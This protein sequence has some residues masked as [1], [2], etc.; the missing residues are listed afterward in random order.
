MAKEKYELIIAE[1]PRVSQKIASALSTGE[2]QQKK[3]GKVSYYIIERNGK[4]IVVAPAVGHIFTLK[5]SGTAFGYPI[6]DIKWVPTYLA[7]KNAYYTREYIENLRELS[8]NAD[9]FVSACDY[10]I[11]GELIGYNVLK[12]ICG[13]DSLK[14]ARRMKFSTLTKEELSNA[15]KN[16]LK[17][18]DFNMAYAGITRHILDWYYGINVS[19][20]LSYAYKAVSGGY[21]TLSAGRVQTPTLR[22]LDDREKEIKAFVPEPFWVITAIL[23]NDINA[24]HKKEKFFKKEDAEGV[25]AKC[26]GKPAVVSKIVKRKTK[27]NPPTPF[28]LGD[29]QSEAY[30]VFKYSPKRTQSLAQSLYEKGLISYPRTSSQKLPKRDIRE[31]LGKLLNQKGYAALVSELLEKRELKAN[32]GK[33]TDPAHPCIYPTGEVPKDLPPAELKLYD[34]IVKRFLATFGKPAIRETQTITFLIDGEEFIAKGTIT[35]EENWFVF[36]SPYVKLKEEELPPVKEKQVL[37]VKKIEKKEDKTKPPNRYSQ[38]SIIRKMEALGIGTKAT[39]A[40]ILQ[41]LY[42]R[43]Y[44]EGTQIKVTLFGSKVI[45]TLSDYVPELTSEK[46]TRKFE[47]EIEKIREGKLQKESVL[48]EAKETLIKILKKFKEH[49]GEIGKR[50]VEEHMRSVREQREIGTCPKCGG[51]LIIRV[52]KKS[53]KQFIGCSNYPKCNVSY[54]LP[55]GA[56][57]VKTDKKCEY[58]GLPIIEVRRRGRRPYRMCIDPNCPSKK[59]WKSNKK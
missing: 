14:K 31:L 45:E 23:E 49:E 15:Y 1:K 36:Y 16:I 5:E 18:I 53:G 46:L 26:K 20:A 39:R 57:I 9:S 22:I 58:D 47:E 8:K 43:G 24:I 41:T 33:K 52:S 2:I 4:K 25:Y 42:D 48:L 59:N 30:K 6:F 34:L 55:Q 13:E 54:P 17:S 3:R 44:V 56:K 38:A 12:F 11:E 10:D 7:N 37:E 40:Q 32:E 28:N 35:I 51:K 19:R 21:L 29:L 50:L 27:Q